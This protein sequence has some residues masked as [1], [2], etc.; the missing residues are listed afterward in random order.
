M[1]AAVTIVAHH[2]GTAGGMESQLGRLVAGLL[3]RGHEVTIV[4]RACRVA[5]HPRLRFVRVTGP[6]R[7]F[8]LRFAWFFVAGSVAAHRHRRGLLHTTGALVA[9]RA[10]VSTVHFCHRAFARTGLTRTDH[11]SLPY[12][13]NSALTTS[14]SRAAEA[15]AYRPSHTRR[16]VGVSFGVAG[17]LRCLFPGVA[18][19]VS[20]IPNGVDLERFKPDPV[21]RQQV[22]AEIAAAP[23]ELIAVFVGTEWERKGLRHAIEALAAA[24]R[25]WLLVAGSGDEVRVRQLAQQTGVAARVRFLG[26]RDDAQRVLAAG[27][28]FVLPTAYESFSLATFEAAACGLP[29]LNTR[30]H[31]VDELL[32]DGVN[33]WFVERDGAEV[34]GRLRAL[35][36]PELRVSMGKQA[37]SAAA[38]FGWD[39]VVDAYAELYERLSAS[40]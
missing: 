35:E 21:A 37:R 32:A 3:E 36:D 28:A 2:V 5:P 38:G 12:R 34:A 8:P 10:D 7:P 29:I 15:L 30:V 27:D 9:N 33:G 31:G 39:P 40:P 11:D 25:W 13:L 19:E 1:P 26:L 23:D 24:P 18:E 22:R 6:D 14:L 16:L 20:T 17:E 4:A